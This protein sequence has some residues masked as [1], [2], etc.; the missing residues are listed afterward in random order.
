MNLWHDIPLGVDAPAEINVIIEVPKGSHNKYEI[1]KETGLIA[2]DRANYSDAAFPYDYGFVPQTLWDDGDALDVIVMTTYP[3]NVGILVAVRPV[4]V[5]EMIDS[6]DSDF[7]VI[8]V[9]VNDKRWEDVQDVGDLNKH[10][11]KEIQHFLE[12]YKLLKGKPAP[13]EI[14]G[15]KGK[16]EAM[17]AVTRSVQLY[18]EKFS[19]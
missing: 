1:D 7:K 9:P 13:V 19:K 2:L 12:T 17:E 14:K 11:V 15:I 18:K 5:I 6:G 4:G 16:A 8:A 10:T 3:L